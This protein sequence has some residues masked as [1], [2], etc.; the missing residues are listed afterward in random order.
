M[1]A[2]IS[3]ISAVFPEFGLYRSIQARIEKIE[4]AI[5]NKRFW[6]R[7]PNED[8][9]VHEIM[10]L[11][12][13]LRRL[14]NNSLTKHIRQ[15]FKE[16]EEIGRFLI[17][18][19]GYDFPRKGAVQ[20][21]ERFILKML[22]EKSEKARQYERA[23]LIELEAV[24]KSREGWFMIFNTLTVSDWHVQA[25]W[26]KESLEW[27]KYVRDFDAA[28]RK[29]AG[30]KIGTARDEYHSY[31]AVI[32]RGSKASKRLHIHV[33]HFVKSLDKSWMDPNYGRNV[34]GYREVVGIKKYWKFGLSVP[35]AV[36][37]GNNDAF[38][39]IGWRW[40]VIKKGRKYERL[41]ANG[42]RAVARYMAK[43]VVKPN[44]EKKIWRTRTSRRFGRKIPQL[45]M[46]NLS[47]ESLVKMCQMNRALWKQ[48]ETG[49]KLPM[50][51]LR[52]E[53]IRE[54]L[55][56]KM[57]RKNKKETPQ[58]LRKRL[59]KEL[60]VERQRVSLPTQLR[61]ARRE[62]EVS[63]IPSVPKSF[64]SGEIQILSHEV[65]SEIESL[66]AILAQ[67]YSEE[68]RFAVG[69]TKDV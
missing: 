40:P 34:P 2:R 25:V 37:T 43:Y 50:R 5:E 55:R 39:K 63:A 27:Q 49:L 20:E 13:M 3:E 6:K 45:L 17:R 38:A 24:E 59:L 31:C 7:V 51:V 14:D 19:F 57:L 58:S 32:E 23:A 67:E 44:E 61:E 64:M 56:R 41:E 8:A 10:R 35:I 29:A 42:V 36:R 18:H 33:L 46:K 68:A 48:S 15:E 62:K 66:I 11:D 4:F 9:V 22:K 26:K 52:E 28:V 47:E 69:R 21:P 1:D 60:S 54:W 30:Y 16:S 65:I 12:Q 53:A